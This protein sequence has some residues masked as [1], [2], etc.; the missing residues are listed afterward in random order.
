MDEDNIKRLYAEYFLCGRSILD[1]VISVD[2]EIWHYALSK[3]TDTSIQFYI[4]NLKR[5]NVSSKQ[6][7]NIKKRKVI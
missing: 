5:A 7:K 6:N 2:K 4:N 3:Q 1:L